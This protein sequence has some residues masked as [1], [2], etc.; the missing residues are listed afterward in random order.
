MTGG[1]R[2]DSMPPVSAQHPMSNADAAWL[3]MDR[4]TNLMI[5]NSVLW[6]DEPLDWDRVKQIFRE[7]VVERFP[8]F[9]RRIVEAGPTR[10]P[11][12]EDVPNFDPEVN[13]HHLALPEPRD[14]H[15]LQELVADLMTE[16]LDRSRPLWRVYLVD[17]YGDGSAVIVRMH[18]CIGDG[19]RLARVMLMLTDAGD[20]EEVELDASDHVAR[21]RRLN[22]AVRPLTTVAGTARRA[23]GVA[24]HETMETIVHPRR[25]P[26]LARTGAVDLQAVVKML[27][28]GADPDSALR[29]EPGFARRVAWS[30]PIGLERVR[31]LGRRA[32]ATINDVLVA[33][34]SGAFA[35]YLHERGTP[36]EEIHAMV[37]FNLESADEPL[38]TELGNRFGLIELTLPVGDGDPADRLRAV[39]TQMDRIKASHEPQMAYGILSAFGLTP[40]AVEGRLL[41]FFTSKSTLV[42]TNVPGP[43]SRVKVAGVPLGGVLVWAP[44][45]GSLGMTVSIFSYSGKVT[46]GLMTDAGL[47][48]DPQRIADAFE[49]ELRALGRALPS[50]SARP[51]AAREGALR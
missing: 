42:M 25:V 37:P 43:R 34:M 31:S 40:P 33:G 19:V 2:S 4:P 6:F 45:S 16:P 24:A 12:W 30:R 36:V 17:G 13:F 1:G 3:H 51:T 14:E 38:P 50:A 27:F 9:R 20:A 22:A 49:A 11:F 18:H 46:V 35:R 41:D 47:V 5:I 32:D 8:R 48:P 7:R 44:C 21:W 26:A 28:T 15:A 23:A 39:K 29:G 10:T